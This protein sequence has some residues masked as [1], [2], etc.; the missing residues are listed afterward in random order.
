MFSEF[1][2]FEKFFAFECKENLHCRWFKMEKFG[3]M[4]IYAL[5]TQAPPT[6]LIF[7]SAFSEK[8]LA[9]TM[10]GCLGRCPL[11]SNL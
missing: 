9:L 4:R 7:F 11:P 10:I 5:K 6:A 8:Y 2:Y 1:F 3:T